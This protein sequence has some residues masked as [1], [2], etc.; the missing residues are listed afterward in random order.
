MSSDQPK[1]IGPY[2]LIH[3]LGRGNLGTVYAARE[4]G[5]EAELAVKVLDLEMVSN[6]PRETALRMVQAEVGAAERL[7]HGNIAGV[8]SMVADAQTPY[9]VMQRVYNGR[10]LSRYCQSENLL[11]LEAVTRIVHGCAQGLH[12]AHERGLVHGDVKPR[13]I[14]LG[15]GLEPKLVDFGLSVLVPNDAR[16]SPR[17]L[18]PEHLKERAI[19]VRSDIFNLGVVL[20]QMMVGRHPFEGD[21][22]DAIRGHIATGRHVRVRKLRSDVPQELQTITNRC[23]AK[24]PGNRYANA[25]HLAADLEVVLDIL[26]ASSSATVRQRVNGLARNLSCFA[27][28]TDHELEE[29]LHSA[30]VHRFRS[31]DEIIA[32][33][34]RAPCVYFVLE[35]EVGIRREEVFEMSHL[36][37]GECVGE[38]GALTGKPR[39][40]TVIALD[41]CTLISVPLSFL[42][43]GPV[44]CRLHL[45]SYLLRTLAARMVESQGAVC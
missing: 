6:L 38:L 24:R 4:A 33:G 15:V 19:D 27:E 41:R 45:Q 17:A 32:A 42:E 44:G 40:A 34:D 43:E 18:T 39:T 30:A 31:G 13:N 12:H 7:S 35:G 2:E 37:A 29:L 26:A 11:P 21:T 14:L 8:L 28:F 9:I 22:L 5:S 1:R 20:Y 16:R 36:G 10:S 3:P 25:L 23:L